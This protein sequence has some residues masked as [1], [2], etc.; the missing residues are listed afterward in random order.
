ML[1]ACLRKNTIALKEINSNKESNVDGMQLLMLLSN[2][3]CPLQR[4]RLSN[5]KIACNQHA[6]REC[7]I[8]A[9]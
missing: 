2:E 3:I 5:P 6:I 9:H 4:T 8:K 1:L 7:E